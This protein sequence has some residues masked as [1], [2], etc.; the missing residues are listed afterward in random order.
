M[1]Q[2]DQIQNYIGDKLSAAEKTDFEQRLSIDAQ[3]KA[4]VEN[5]QDM[6]AAFKFN[7][8][9]ELKKHFQNLESA[10]VNVFEKMVRS[11]FFY[12]GIAALFVLGIFIGKNITGNQNLY[13]TYF[14]TYPN[15]YRPITRSQTTNDFTDAFVA[16]ENS[17]FVTA[18]K[19]F[20][21][22][23]SSNDDDNLRFYLALSQMQ[24][25]KNTEA[26][27]QLEKINIQNT[28]F[29]HEILWYK[30][31]LYI[32]N[33]NEKSAIENLK[34]LESLES[35]FKVDERQALLKKLE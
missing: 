2:E 17:D 33:K 4:A 5:H 1:T 8:A 11:P 14:D 10:R 30:S 26:I 24:L 19:E 22:L 31:L 34:T 23:L 32:K 12:A 16:Y 29:T 15:V 25:D 13:E 18:E 35:K 21:S 20:E 9:A 28:E 7:E 27:E 3:L 6:Q